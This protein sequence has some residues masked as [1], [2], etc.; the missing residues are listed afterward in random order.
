[1]NIS[2]R[3]FIKMFLLSYLLTPSFLPVSSTILPECYS[4]KVHEDQK[5]FRTTERA[6]QLLNQVQ[7]VGLFAYY[8]LFVLV[9]LSLLNHSSS[10]T[11]MAISVASLFSH[12]G[13]L[14]L[15][16]TLPKLFHTWWPAGH[17][18][19]LDFHTHR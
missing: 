4:Q 14:L 11:Y 3:S 5:P 8:F 13:L 9:L 18:T 16:F 19:K 10:L 12:R 6:Q 2:N 15:N 17:I 7:E 1:M